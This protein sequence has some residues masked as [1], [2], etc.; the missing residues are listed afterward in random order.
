[1]HCLIY[2]LTDLLSSDNLG[3]N[4]FKFFDFQIFNLTVGFVLISKG[5]KVINSH[6]YSIEK[7]IISCYPDYLS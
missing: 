3:Q 7:V 2:N 6:F 4:N 5:N 1:M